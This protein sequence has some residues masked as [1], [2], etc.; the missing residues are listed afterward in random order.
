MSTT[1]DYSIID[2]IEGR[3]AQYVYEIG[4]TGLI[5]F[6]PSILLRIWQ[7]SKFRGLTDME[8]AYLAQRLRIH[9]ELERTEDIKLYNM[10][11]NTI[12]EKADLFGIIL[13][14]MV[15]VV[16]IILIARSKK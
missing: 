12:G 5:G 10:I 16:G 13:F 11:K 8:C 7:E 1:Q 2:D 4:E 14:G 9:F 15:A 3:Y 6:S